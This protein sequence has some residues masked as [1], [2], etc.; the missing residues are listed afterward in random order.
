MRWLFQVALAGMSYIP[1]GNAQA[2][3]QE[4]LIA[5]DILEIGV[6]YSIATKNIPAFERYILQLKWFYYDYK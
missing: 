2:N 1:T 3:Q 6:E 5:R 4:L